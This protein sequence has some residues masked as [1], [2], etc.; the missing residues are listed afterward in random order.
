MII[1]TW[2]DCDL[3]ELSIDR[4]MGHGRIEL[5]SMDNGS[6]LVIVDFRNIFAVKISSVFGLDSGSLP[7]F[8]GAVTIESLDA[9][10]AMFAL[11]SLKYGFSKMSDDGNFGLERQKVFRIRVEGSVVEAEIVSAKCEVTA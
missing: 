1:G 10:E 11:N 8:V 7:G 2:T 4:N 6:T 9:S 3:T 5:T